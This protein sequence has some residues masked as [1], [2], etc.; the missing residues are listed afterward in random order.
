MSNPFRQILLSVFMLGAVVTA[1]KA[2]SPQ[3]TITDLGAFTAK[4]INNSSSVAGTMGVP[5]QAVLVRGGVVTNITPAGSADA[6]ASGINDLD[7]VVGWASF[8]DMVGGNCTNSRVRGFIF[9]QG[10]WTVLG[11]L[12][13]RNSFA[14]SINNAGH[15]TGESFIAG[16]SPGTSGDAHAYIFRNGAFEDIGA[17]AP[18]ISSTGF[19]INASGQVAGKG[20]GNA[21][22]SNG[23][24][25]YTNGA[26]LFFE[27][28]GVA[29]DLNDSGQ[30]VGVFGGNDDG[31]G[32]AFLFTGG[33]R[34][35][36]GTLGSGYNYSNAFGINNSGHVVGFSSPSFFSSQGERAFIFSN[37]VMQDLNNLIP[38]TSGWVLTRASD[39]NDA[40]QIVGNG[41]LN[42]QE[43]AY[44]LTPT[45][46]LL[47]TE[48]NSNK[49]IVL[50][51]V[52]HLRDPFRLTSPHFLSSDRRTRLTILARNIE[53]RPGE[54]IPPPSVQ[55][56]D[57]Q[58]RL[59]TLP[60]EFI[61]KVPEFDWLTQI[62]VKLPDELASAG[63]VQV[64]ILF[65]GKTSNPATFS[66]AAPSP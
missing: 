50:D 32:R 35:D 54:N 61:G 26:F 23:A 34:Q 33:V 36:L 13:G 3:Y 49:A 7:Q 37:G 6:Q 55:A 46:P 10:S 43:R 65:R 16:P 60:V 66:I 45:Q 48:S 4:A 15:V 57:A 51:S 63:E 24:F 39:I 42:G 19:S 12:G 53:I 25:I 38:S 28:Q 20:S 44:L 40:G 1:T 47:L 31:S 56:E 14:Y 8:C 9:N 62:V 27:T 58:H 18:T 29:R 22:T 5:L 52:V 21:S 30:T 59:I 64:R 2:Q 17:T 11:T 41:F